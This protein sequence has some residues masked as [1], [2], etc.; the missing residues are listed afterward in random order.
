MLLYL[1]I[2]LLSLAAVA[3]EARQGKHHGDPHAIRW[4]DCAQHV[5]ESTAPTGGSFN[6]STV[7]LTKLPSSLHCGQID[8]PM[9]YSKPFCD[10]NKITL[11]LA[12]YRPPKPKG[13][14]FFCPGGTDPGVVTIWEAAL[15]I[16]D[17]LNGLLDFELVAMDIRGTFTSN[18]LNVSL[19]LVIALTGMPLP[20]NESDYEAIKA[21]SGATIQSWVDHSTPPG[22]IEHVGTREVTQDYEMIREALGYHKINFLGAS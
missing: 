17:A 11:G 7:D 14:L 9:D 8:V 20:T 4:V 6:S 22:I 15:N 10:D 18:P 13:P 16:S 1:K 5:P 12:T 19:D 21:A 3:T 2:A